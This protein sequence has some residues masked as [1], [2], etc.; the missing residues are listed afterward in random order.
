[1]SRTRDP[2][3]SPAGETPGMYDDSLIVRRSIGE[4]EAFAVLFDRHSA[5][6]YRYLVKRVGP[7]LADDLVAETFLVA[8]A[9]RERYD[10][11]RPDARPWLL[12]IATNLL[13]RHRRREARF[14][15]A[16]ARTGADPSA[17]PSAAGSA[18][19]ALADDVAD[20]VAAQG[21]R[22]QLAA[23]L[24]SLS[25]GER[26]VVLLIAAAGLGYAEVAV[27]LGVPV[28]TVSSRLVRARHKLRQALG[29]VDPRKEHQP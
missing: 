22:K 9:A 5:T 13:G 26:D 8:F 20:R 2:L 25:R 18:G 7:D 4:P 27:T 28:G 17:A 11:S 12:G 10:T 6:I 14:F 23:G 1:L 3:V 21:A 16:I 24:A 19:D 29:D 15:R